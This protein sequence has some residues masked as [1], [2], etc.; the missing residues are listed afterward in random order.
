M[1]KILTKSRNFFVCGDVLYKT[2]KQG[3]SDFPPLLNYFLDK[4]TFNLL[5]CAWLIYQKEDIYKFQEEFLVF[6]Y[7]DSIQINLLPALEEIAVRGVKPYKKTI[8]S[9]VISNVEGKYELTKK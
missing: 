2:K 3:L 6:S 7:K 1:L 5:K 4:E 9:L 8:K